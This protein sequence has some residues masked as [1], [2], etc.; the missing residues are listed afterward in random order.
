MNDKKASN[1]I[2]ITNLISDLGTYKY[3]NLDCRPCEIYT[4]QLLEKFLITGFQILDT[5]DGHLLYLELKSEDGNTVGFSIPDI[6]E[7]LQVENESI[8][9]KLKSFVRRFSR[10]HAGIK[11]ARAQHTTAAASEDK[12]T[13]AYHAFVENTMHMTHEFTLSKE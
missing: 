4:R 13:L 11:L 5:L 3:I 7:V 6:I 8:K 9:Y 10:E 1:E 2:A 12:M